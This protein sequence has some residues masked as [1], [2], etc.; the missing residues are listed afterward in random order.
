MNNT[1]H[2]DQEGHFALI[3][4]EHTG[5]PLLFKA[6]NLLSKEERERDYINTNTYGDVSSDKGWIYIRVQLNANSS[7]LHL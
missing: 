3:I 7:S 5:N 1:I 6:H 2:G 4:D